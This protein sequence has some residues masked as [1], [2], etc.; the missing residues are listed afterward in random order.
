MRTSERADWVSD[1]AVLDQPAAAVAGPASENP[2]MTRP[3]PAPGEAL[4]DREQQILEFIS[5]GWSNPQ[6][7]REFY[8]TEDTVKSHV[9][10]LLAKLEA[11]GRAHAVR[12]GFELGLLGGSDRV[13]M[14]ME[15]FE[16]LKARWY[17]EA[18]YGSR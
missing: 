12:R 7:G 3:L 14:S 18:L 1:R 9:R 17:A 16:A 11:S 6:I 4:T 5:Q 8:I 13:E 10:R 15:E 2:P